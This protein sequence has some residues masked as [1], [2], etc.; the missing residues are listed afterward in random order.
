MLT[1]MR[2]INHGPMGFYFTMGENYKENMNTESLIC[3]LSTGYGAPA[4]IVG[5]AVGVRVHEYGNNIL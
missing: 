2:D 5:L 3:A 4:I 1:E